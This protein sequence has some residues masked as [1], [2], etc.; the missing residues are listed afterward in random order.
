MES[1]VY[2]IDDDVAVRRR[3]GIPGLERRGGV[4]ACRYAGEGEEA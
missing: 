3:E 1:V 2:L 4:G